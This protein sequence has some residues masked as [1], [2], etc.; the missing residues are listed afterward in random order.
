MKRR[1]FVGSGLTAL[2]GCAKKE[3]PRVQESSGPPSPVAIVKA[4]SYEIDLRDPIR[5]AI[6]EC[7]LD[8]RGKNVLLKPN[9]VEFSQST[10]IN[11]NPAFVA[12]AVEVFEGMGAAS[13]R[14]GEGPGHRRD[15]WGLAEQA[16][17]VSSIPGFESRFIDL[18]RD[19]LS[20]AGKFGPLPEIY[21]PNAALGS[22]LI[23][24]LAKMKT[25]HWA[26][27]TLSMKNFFGVVPGT[28]YG[29][30]KNQLHYVGIPQSI[31][32]LNRIFRR[33]FALVD[34][35]VG[36]EGNGPIQGKPRQAGVIVAG[37]D[38]V[39]VDATCCRLMSIDP[40][41]IEYLQLARDLGHV[42]ES[43]I[44]QRGERID[45]VRQKFELIP[46]WEQIRLA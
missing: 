36:M 6:A 11:T 38:L 15:T 27:A 9:F 4:A 18:N 31:V 29:W 43:R 40:D 39:A 26:G 42:S 21:L 10:C 2:V 3:T 1:T 7:R 13:V 16:G 20:K 46:I 44:E 17:Y 12:A 37:R 28:L 24:S 41:K 8:V 32:E 45:S 25:H 14:I 35:V 23:V 19:E 22:D 34:G 5:R 33:T 30:P